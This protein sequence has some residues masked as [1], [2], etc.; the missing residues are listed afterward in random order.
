MLKWIVYGM[1]VFILSFG[2][3][4]ILTGTN[5]ELEDDFTE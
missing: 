1:T 4:A 2:L 3:A 5:G